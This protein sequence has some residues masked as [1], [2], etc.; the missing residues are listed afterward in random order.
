MPLREV[1]GDGAR[2]ARHI[3]QRI[4]RRSAGRVLRQMCEEESGAV[5][6]ARARERAA[7]GADLELALASFGGRGVTAV[8]GFP[9]EQDAGL[10]SGVRDVDA[11]EVLAQHVVHRRGHV[12]QAAAGH[13]DDVGGGVGGDEPRDVAE[14]V[15]RARQTQEHD[16]SVSDGVGVEPDDPDAIAQP[17]LLGVPGDRLFTGQGILMDADVPRAIMRGGQGESAVGIADR[18]DRP[19][20]CTGAEVD[21]LVQDEPVGGIRCHQIR[22]F[23]VGATGEPV[24]GERVGSRHLTSVGEG[25]GRFVAGRGILGG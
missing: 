1:R 3:D 15:E 17:E 19:G 16:P 21:G 25:I 7:E 13:H 14:R 8:P 6:E 5:V 24:E 22:T 18:D 23:D 9:R 2:S 4:L 20:R 12:L 10:L 11:S